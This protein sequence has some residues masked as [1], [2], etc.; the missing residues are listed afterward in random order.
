MV[1]GKCQAGV[2]HFA[3]HLGQSLHLALAADHEGGALVDAFGLDVEDAVA[4]ADG[5]MPPACSA[6]KASGLAS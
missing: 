6:M 1:A 5:C 2:G 3:N 4:V